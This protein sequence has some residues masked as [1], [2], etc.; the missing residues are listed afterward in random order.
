MPD[1][2][3]T[4][5]ELNRTDKRLS[6]EIH[7]VRTIVE[8]H[9]EEIS[10]LKVL[11]KTLEDL[12]TTFHNLDKTLTVVCNNLESIQGQMTE[13]KSSVDEQSNA[14]KNLQK[15]DDEQDEEILRVDN[16]GKV[17]WVQAIT[18]NFWK[19]LAAFA[20]IYVVIYTFINK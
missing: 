9:T 4:K 2:V 15:N 12:P 14:I 18:Q 20:T 13:I 8:T 10:R 16:K 7:E 3:V 1:E 19:I 17:D 6:G 5:Y 11:Y